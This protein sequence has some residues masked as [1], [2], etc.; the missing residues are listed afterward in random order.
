[1]I[2]DRITS[3]PAYWLVRLYLSLSLVILT[4]TA[5]FQPGT[6]LHRLVEVAGAGFWVA[7]LMALCCLA[8]LDAII[9]DLLPD[10]WQMR[11]AKD[12][13]HIVYMLMSGGAALMAFEFYKQAGISTGAFL[14]LV[15]SASVAVAVAVADLFARHKK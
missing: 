11:W 10:R 14:H 9:N 12:R 6:R 2:G 5:L 13:R 4:G 3:L 15:L 1:M 8:A 7:A